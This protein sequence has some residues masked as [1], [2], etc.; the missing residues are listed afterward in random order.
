MVLNSI[1]NFFMKIQK[2]VTLIIGV[3]L[4]G[5]A[6]LLASMP[7]WKTRSY[8]PPVTTTPAST[9]TYSLADI[10]SHR[11][12]KNCWTLVGGVVYDLTSWIAA[13]PGGDQ[14]IISMCGKDAT[15]AFADQHGGQRRPEQILKTFQIGTLK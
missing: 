6:I 5:G 11:D 14:A 7:A 9:S 12:E 1:I 8:V 10:A 3:G 13:H 2:L 4:V 15:Q